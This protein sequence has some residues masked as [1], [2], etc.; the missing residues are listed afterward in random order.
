MIMTTLEAEVDPEQWEKLDE[1]FREG[2]K[3]LPPQIV[4]TFLAYS[5]ADP[6]VWRIITLWRS[7]EA[8]DE[9]RQMTGTPGGVL[10]FRRAGVEPTLHI[11]EIVAHGC[12]APVD[13]R[14]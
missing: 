7:R 13:L 10:M 8:L 11:T 5:G 6:N 12:G 9:Y 14:A 2:T 1:A 4:Q 3:T